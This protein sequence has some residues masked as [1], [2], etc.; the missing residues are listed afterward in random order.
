VHAQ[1][2]RGN[3]RGKQNQAQL[4][5]RR[6][7][8]HQRRPE[9]VYCSSMARDTWDRWPGAARCE[10]DSARKTCKPNHGG[11]P[12]RIQH[13]R[14]DEPWRVEIHHHQHEDI[15]RPDAQRAPAI[16]VCGSN[17]PYSATSRRMDVMRKPER[18]K[19]EIDARPSPTARGSRARCLSRRGLAVVDDHGQT[20][21]PR[22]LQ[23]GNVGGQPGWALDGKRTTLAGLGTA[24]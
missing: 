16:E 7:E 4:H 1:Q 22:S 13:A 6:E 14:A 12:D 20:A 11:G 8:A 24:L 9:E 19:K 5:G 18:T 15:D 21:M 2:R 10:K 3:E 23:F 17:F